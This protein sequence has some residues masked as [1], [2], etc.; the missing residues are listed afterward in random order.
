MEALGEITVPET[1]PATEWIL[2]GP[3]QKVSPQRR[4]AILQLELGT[5]LSRWAGDRGEVGTEWRFGVTPPGERTR[6]L[7]PDVAYLSFARMRGLTPEERETPKLAPDIVVEIVSPDDRIAHVDHKRQV[8]LAAGVGLLLIVDPQALTMDAYEPGGRHRTFGPDDTFTTPAF[9]G[10][11][12]PLGEV[13]AKL[14][15]PG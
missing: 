14:A 10:L 8:Y 2:G 7:V 6:P 9:P 1:K 12:I 15:I 13:F 11:T 5:R 3:V 4:H